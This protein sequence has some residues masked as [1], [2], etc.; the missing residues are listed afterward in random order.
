[1]VENLQDIRASIDL[2]DDQL[3]DLICRR[4]ELSAAVASAKSGGVTYRPGMSS[5]SKSEGGPSKRTQCPPTVARHAKS[6]KIDMS[7]T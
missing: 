6:T 4:M 5:K 3:L 7:N 2:I 1:M